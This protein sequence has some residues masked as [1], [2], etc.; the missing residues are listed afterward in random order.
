MCLSVREALQKLLRSPSAFLA[1]QSAAAPGP[2][3]AFSRARDSLRGFAHL[4]LLATLL[5]SFLVTLSREPQA[6]CAGLL[7]VAVLISFDH[8]VGR[9]I[10][11]R[12]KVL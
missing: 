8:G 4:G 10:V 3:P 6:R 7:G 2:L 5:Q 12:L 9:V 11:Y 1:P